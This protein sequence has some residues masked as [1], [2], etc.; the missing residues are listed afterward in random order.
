[1][2]ALVELLLL[3]DRE[4]WGLTLGVRPLSSLLFRLGDWEVRRPW[5]LSLSLDFERC[6]NVWGLLTDGE[7][8]EDEELEVEGERLEGLG[9]GSGKGCGVVLLPMAALA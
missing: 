4:G 5:L 1:M 8:P 2:Y 7:R 3:G 9:T 6:W